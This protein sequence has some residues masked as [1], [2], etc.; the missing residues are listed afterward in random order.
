MFAEL[1]GSVVSRM[2]G[3][4]GA[5]LMGFDGI[6]IESVTGNEPGDWQSTTIELGSIAKQ[7]QRIS[8]NM[9]TGDVREL[10]VKTGALTTVL[11]PLTPEYFV[12]LVLSTGANA[13]K[14]RYLLRVVGPK[15]ERELA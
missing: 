8:E 14:A 1:L 11:R 13:G 4:V 9:G 2:S 7:L 12:A 5:T 3:V 6:A 15:L 10:I